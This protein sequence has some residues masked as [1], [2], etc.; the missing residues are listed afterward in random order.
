M[1][2][3]VTKTVDVDKSILCYRLNVFCI[4]PRFN[5]EIQGCVSKRSGKDRFNECCL[6]ESANDVV[7]TD[8]IVKS[9]A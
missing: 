5:D 6:L 7:K 3:C 8:N 4:E 1:E 2:T 9:S